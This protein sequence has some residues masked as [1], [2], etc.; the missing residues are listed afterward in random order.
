MKCGERK[1]PMRH[2]VRFRHIG[3]R[4]IVLALLLLGMLALI[5]SSAQAVYEFPW[6][7]NGGAVDPNGL[8]AGAEMDPDGLAV[9]SA[10][11]PNGLTVGSTIDHNGLT[12]GSTIDPNGLAVGSSMDPL[13]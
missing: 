6:Q 7:A 5:G 8:A 13:G 1:E 4:L 9:G 10:I 11:D 3:S 2:S 12:V